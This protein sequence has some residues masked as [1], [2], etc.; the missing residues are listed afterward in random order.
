VLAPACTEKLDDSPCR[1]CSCALRLNPPHPVELYDE[2]IAAV[3]A[4]ALLA[5]SARPTTGH[6]AFTFTVSQVGNNVVVNGSGSLITTG[7]PFVGNY[8]GFPPSISP[9]IGYLL[10][11]TSGASLGF[12]SGISRPSSFG[13]SFAQINGTGTGN[14]VGLEQGR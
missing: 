12:Y 9:N 4:V 13:T 1:G 14:I 5:T 11:G 8:S 2:K 7:L 3:F 10:S 6:V